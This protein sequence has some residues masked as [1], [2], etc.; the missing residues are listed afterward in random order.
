M[1]L[2]VYVYIKHI[3]ITF[4]TC[5]TTT[6]NVYIYIIIYIP[7]IAWEVQVKCAV[8]RKE[9]LARM[10]TIINRRLERKNGIE[11]YVEG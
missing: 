7:T 2:Y 8:P 6:N 10:E 9:R 11:K 3:D 5:M 1:Y 4:Y